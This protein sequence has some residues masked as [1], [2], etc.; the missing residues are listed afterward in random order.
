MT[1][2]YC[3]H[4]FEGKRADAKFCSAR[5]RV[6]CS[7]NS[8]PVTDTE[9]LKEYHCPDCGYTFKARGVVFPGPLY[10]F[11]EEAKGFVEVTA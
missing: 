11:S 2:L 9:P 7:R 8:Q 1:C 3:H 6:A 4:P 10:R 5:C